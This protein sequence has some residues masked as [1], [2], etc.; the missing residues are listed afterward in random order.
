MAQEFSP[1]QLEKLLKYASRRLN[2][3]PEALKEIFQQQGLFGLAQQAQAADV[4]SEKTAAE[5][6]ALLKD[7]E[8]TAQLMNSPAVQQLLQQL[9]SEP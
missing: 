1:Q 9:L 2:T 4:I 8:K 5:T 6:Q 7:K 3:T